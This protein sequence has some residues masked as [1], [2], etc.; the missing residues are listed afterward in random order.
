MTEVDVHKTIE[1]L[2]PDFVLGR[3]SHGEMARVQDHTAECTQC[4]SFL[5]HCRTLLDDLVTFEQLEVRQHLSEDF[6]VRYA[7]DPAAL[8]ESKKGLVETHLL[9]CGTCTDELRRLKELDS[10]LM[11]HDAAKAPIA[12]RVPF[13]SKAVQWAL[14]PQ[15]A[16]AIAAAVI[17]TFTIWQLLAPRRSQEHMFAD[18]LAVESAFTLREQTRNGG[19]TPLVERRPN[20]AFLRLTFSFWPDTVR[21]YRVLL[22][23]IARQPTMETLLARHLARQGRALITLKADQLPDGSYTL[24]LQGVNDLIPADTTQARYLFRLKTIR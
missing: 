6:L 5:A 11:G 24:I 13:Y 9:F 2:I 17:L 12:H 23:G 22:Q 4:A 8:N 15:V 10:A 19:D 18:S 14:R 16:Y 21:S 7:E 20:D 3:L 1:L